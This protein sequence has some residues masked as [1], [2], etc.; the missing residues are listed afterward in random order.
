MNQVERCTGDGESVRGVIAELK[1]LSDGAKKLDNPSVT[2]ATTSGLDAMITHLS[3]KLAP[4]RS[5]EELEQSLADTLREL[6]RALKEH[7]NSVTQRKELEAKLAA[8]RSEMEAKTR[9]IDAMRQESE[10]ARRIEAQMTKMK[11]EQEALKKELKKAQE[12]REDARERILVL[13]RR[14]HNLVTTNESLKLD[15]NLSLSARPPS[16]TRQPSEPTPTKRS[17]RGSVISIRSQSSPD[18]KFVSLVSSDDEVR[19]PT[20]SSSVQFISDDDDEPTLMF[21]EIKQKIRPVKPLLFQ[22]IP[23]ASSSR[24]PRSVRKRKLAASVPNTPPMGASS[25]GTANSPVWSRQAPSVLHEESSE[26]SAD[27][28]RIFKLFLQVRNRFVWLAA[29]LVAVLAYLMLRARITQNAIS[30][31]RISASARLFVTQNNPRLQ[32]ALSEHAAQ[33]RFQFRPLATIATTTTPTTH[34]L[35]GS[36]TIPTGAEAFDTRNF[37]LLQRVKLDYADVEASDEMEKQRDRIDRPPIVKGYFVVATEIFNDSGCPHTLEHLVFLGSEQYPYKGVLDNLANRAFSQGTN[38]WTDTD[39]TAYTISTAGS[40][41]FLQLLPVY[42]DHILYPRITDADFVTEVHHINSKAEDAGVVYSEMQGRQNTAG[43]LMYH[44]LQTLFNPPGSAYRS[45]TGGLMEALRILKVD[46]IRDYHKS[47]YVPHNLCLIVSG[48]LQT[49]ELLHVL[50]TKVEPRILEHG[51]VKP[52]TWKR[53]FIETPS[54][55]KPALKGNTK[56]TVDFPEQDESAGEVAVSFQGPEPE[57]F[58]ELKAMELLGL[59]LTDSPVSP[60]T[61]EFVENANPLCTSIYCDNNERATFTSSNIYFSSVPTEQLDALH[62]KVIAKL[63]QVVAEG[64]DMDRIRLVI[65]RDKLKLKSM[66]ESDGGDVFSNGLI[67]D[68]LY[69]KED[70]S[71]IAPSLAEMQRYEELEKWSAKQWEDLLTKY[72]IES[73]SVIVGARPSA[74][75]QDKLETDEKAR[76]EAQRKRLGPEG[77]A[78][79]EEELNKAKAEHDRPIPQDMLTSFPVPDVKGISWIPVQSARN[80]PFSAKSAKKNELSEHLDKDPIDLPYFVQYD[81]VQSDF[82]T[83]S[84]YLST[85][86]LPERLRP[87]ISLYLSSF[88]ALP[89]TQLDGTKISHEDLVKKLDEVTV[90]YDANCGI[91]GYFADTVRISIKAEVSQ[92]DAVV[93]LLRDLLYSP[94]YVK[95]RLEVNVAKILQSLPEQKRDGNTI[96]T[97]ISNS[98][99]FETSKSVSNAGGIITQME[100]IPELAKKLQESPDEVVKDMK[101]FREHVTNPHGIRFTVG[102]NVLAL[103]Q[104]RSAWK[105]KFE[106]IKTDSLE[107]V[108]WSKDVLSALGEDPKKKAVVVSMPTIESSYAMHTAQ[109]VVG[110]D[111]P[112]YPALRLACEV[113][114]GTESFLWKLIRGSGLAYGANMSLDA[115]SGLLSFLLYRAPDSYK[116]FQAGAKAVRGLVDGTIELDETA[117]DAAKSSLVFSLTRRVASPGKAALDSF[118]NQVLKKVP[119][120][121]GRELLDRIQA[122][123]LEGVRRALKTQVLPLFDPA[124]SIA[125]VASSASKS[126]DIAEGLKSSG[127]D[128][129]LRTLDLSGDED[130]DDSG[131]EGGNSGSSGSVRVSSLWNFTL[132][133]LFLP[134][135]S[136][137]FTMPAYVQRPAPAFS[138]TAVEDGM[139]KEISLKDYLG[140]WVVLFFWPMDFTFVCPTEILAFNRA[141]PRF[142]ELGVQLIGVSTDSEYA[143]LAWANTP[144]KAGGIGPDMKILLASD[145]SHKISRDYG[146]LIEDEGIALRG[147]FII[148]PKGILRQITIN[149]LPVGRSVDETIRLVEAFQFTHGEVCPANW[150]KGDITI[151]P[152]PTNSLEYFAA[153]NPQDVPM[154]NG[155][156][157]KRVAEADDGASKKAKAN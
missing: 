148:D 141:L 65:K 136:R 43:D 62:E 52:S 12:D 33:S 111:H 24:P 82:V 95:D 90:A 10:R 58:T 137:L 117:L 47:Y 89:V 144:A 125:V 149:D 74:K 151:K 75:L 153:A 142:H 133:Q 14:N 104:P 143:H 122:V 3:K 46:Q 15:L 97:A 22:Q 55:Q 81:H 35:P 68:F 128:V 48:K 17:S 103:E 146:V 54:A 129:E 147:L 86:S 2:Q 53:P 61:K 66:L 13:K 44:K 124:T 5:A 27:W 1:K 116:G 50:Q 93:G 60:L 112:D 51:Q 40:Q 28:P 139:F 26:V 113:L 94:E 145:K 77:I 42:V 83:I 114:D 59:Y 119:Q 30:A 157:K 20:E 57:N 106:Q 56:A 154:T 31:R 36:M 41:G 80:D 84:A 25:L 156:A 49:S 79:L 101:E 150:N 110:F 76:I 85:T 118:V 9:T 99:T 63:K 39:H 107:P 109:G 87:Y 155:T 126:S 45:E 96:M 69:G 34:Q 152:D 11:A 130:T 102:G 100:F 88:F 108:S 131:S 6:D 29:G 67:T 7:K 105:N 32:G 70:G 19:K 78:K 64:I 18:T 115:E 37:E 8:Q 4:L 135:T 120:D 98:L 132:F 92:Y 134:P 38:A 140:K 73:P 23:H 91:S 138:T 123:D 121:H 21:R 71:D 127:F 16:P 72:W